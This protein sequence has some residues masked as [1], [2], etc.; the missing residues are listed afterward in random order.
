M[1]LIQLGNHSG[2]ILTKL[3]IAYFNLKEYAC[4]VE[5]LA[6]IAGMEQTETSFYISALAYKELKDRRKAI[7][8]LMKAIDAGVSPNISDYYSEIGSSYELL[9][10]FKKAVLAYQK[11]LQFEEKPITYY[12]MATLYDNKLKNKRLALNYYKKYITAKPPLKQ[13]KYKTYAIGRI[14]E[15]S[16]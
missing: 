16:H 10:K 7:E 6:D 8:N 3:G 12:L 13:E 14:T 9:M 1:K 4:C 11:G 15:L 5:T 2:Y